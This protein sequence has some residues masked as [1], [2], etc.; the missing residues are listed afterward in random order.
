MSKKIV[1]DVPSVTPRDVDTDDYE[2]PAMQFKTIPATVPGPDA[3]PVDDES[4]EKTSQEPT[5]IRSSAPYSSPYQVIDTP[6]DN[7]RLEEICRT[8][9]ERDPGLLVIHITEPLTGKLDFS[10][11][12]DRAIQEIHLADNGQ[13]THLVGL[14][15]KL[16]KLTC[17]HNQLTELD[18]LP[19]TLLELHVAHNQLYS[20]DF[21]QASQLRI[22]HGE[23]NR[24]YSVDHLP[25]TIEEIHVAHNQLSELN[26]IGLT[27]LRVLDCQ[28]N[29]H[30]M[31]LKH[32]PS[33][34]FRLLMDE[35]PMN[36]LQVADTEAETEEASVAVKKAPKIAY[37]EAFNQYMMYKS[38]YEQGVLQWRNRAS[39]DKKKRTFPKCIHCAANVGMTFQRKDGHYTATCGA[40]P[41]KKNCDFHIDL[42]AG[43]YIS[44][45]DFFREETLEVARQQ[46]AFMQQKMQTLF[47][48]MDEKSS[49]EIF[50]QRLESYVTATEFYDILTKDYLGLYDN[51]SQQDLIDRQIAKIAE[52]K[53]NIHSLLNEYRNDAL[54]KS[55]LHDAMELH[56]KSLLPEIEQLRRLRHP[57]MEMN[58]KVDQ[59]G[60]VLCS[61]L[62][63]EPFALEKLTYTLKSPEVLAYQV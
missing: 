60:N 6:T 46:E 37:P 28:F 9:F 33:H 17:N 58:H 35:G 2:T 7:P 34:S 11:V 45:A 36:Q 41:D 20:L 51:P 43:T 14:P 42:L 53:A 8:L 55:L 50:K 21:S 62:Y 32:V 10:F 12:S 31:I 24:L 63:Q 19:A 54:N 18:D 26:L 4:Q 49:A 47:G 52:H 38:R 3:G 57:V 13:V 1:F 44:L 39:T 16:Q 5:S 30:P 59:H 61:M 22:F 29:R 23:H 27:Q 25:A 15:P 56:V 48:Y 40:T